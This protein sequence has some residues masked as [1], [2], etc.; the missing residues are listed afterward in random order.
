MSSIVS[1]NDDSILDHQHSQIIEINSDL[2]LSIQSIKRQEMIVRVN[3]GRIKD[4]VDITGLKLWDFGVQFARYLATKPNFFTNKKI[5]ELG[6]GCGTLSLA[7]AATAN[8]AI[9]FTITDAAEEA[10]SLIELNKEQ[11]KTKL[12]V[13]VEVQKCWWTIEEPKESEPLP[14][15]DIVLGTDLLYHLTTVESLFATAIRHMNKETGVFFL[16][17]MS[18]Y[19]GTIESIRT[20]ATKLDL[21]LQ[22]ISLKQMKVLSTED[23]DETTSWYCDGMFL[24]VIAANINAIVPILTALELHI[25]DN[26]TDDFEEEGSDY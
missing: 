26:V 7:L 21:S 1:T 22:F 17:G 5:I 10:L 25:D 6:S 23:D 11:N 3:T 16:G 14:I 24:A 13:P 20:A 15:H 8:Q 18:R 2:S 12:R 4:G 19:Y 9:S